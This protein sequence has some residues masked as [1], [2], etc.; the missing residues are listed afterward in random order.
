MTIAELLAEFNQQRPEGVIKEDELLRFLSE[1]EGRIKK[2]IIDR[3]EGGEKIEFAGY[4]ENTDKG[5]EL[6]VKAP[7][8]RLYLHYLEARAD[9]A[10]GD[11]RRYENS[12]AMF[13]DA[14]SAFA[15]YYNRTV[16]PKRTRLKYF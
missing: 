7:Y 15:K 9:Y 11:T 4:D 16:M 14:M 13:N 1:I 12:Y 3:H 10:I 2:E 8:D 5:T 6:I